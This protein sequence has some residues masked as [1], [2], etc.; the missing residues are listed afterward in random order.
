[1]MRLLLVLVALMTSPVFAEE[2][3][4]S[5]N[6]LTPAQ[7]FPGKVLAVER[8]WVGYRLFIESLSETDKKYCVAKVWMSGGIPLEYREIQA[9]D[10]PQPSVT[11][12]FLNP[13]IAVDG[14]SWSMGVWKIG[15][16]FGGEDILHKVLAAKA[17]TAPGPL[18]PQK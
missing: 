4:W 15:K 9:S 18:F 3:L 16:I 14:F 8:S 7:P 5:G 2:I 13:S 10:L 11:A 17:A 1:M 6:K 12:I